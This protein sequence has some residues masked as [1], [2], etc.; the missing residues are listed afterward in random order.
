MNMIQESK[1]PLQCNFKWIL[2]RNCEDT[3]QLRKDFTVEE[4]TP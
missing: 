2:Q 3:E 4:V 1:I